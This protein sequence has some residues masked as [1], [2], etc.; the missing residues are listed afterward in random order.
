MQ[1][2]LC[3]LVVAL[4]LHLLAGPSIPS[5]PFTV[6]ASR[7]LAGDYGKL[8]EWQKDAYERGLRLGLSPQWQVVLTAYY[9]SE[10][11]SGKYDC[12]GARLGP[13]AA[14]SNLIPQ[15]WYIWTPYSGLRRV[16]DR[17]ATSNDLRAAKHRAIWVD[18]W[19]PS[20]AH[21]RRKGL[22]GWRLTKAVLIPPDD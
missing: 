18:I 1:C 8:A 17:G 6:T 9:P 13:H 4:S 5:N 16:C 12:R 19:M 21:A 10:G 11:H 2:G 7:A 20:A 14:S 3:S 22:D 15:G